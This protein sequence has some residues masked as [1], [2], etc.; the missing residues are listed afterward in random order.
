MEKRRKVILDKFDTQLC[1]MSQL[2][3]YREVAAFQN[4]NS[5]GILRE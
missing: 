5:E 4:G 2:S 1:A 3:I